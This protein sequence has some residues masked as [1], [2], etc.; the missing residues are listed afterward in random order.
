M[1]A[2]TSSELEALPGRYRGLLLNC[3]TAPKPAFLVGTRG[4]SS[5]GE[6]AVD[7]LSLF[8]QVIHLGANPFLIGLVI[9]PDVVERHT[10]RNLRQ[11]GLLTLSIV[12]QSMLPAAHQCSAK[13]PSEVSEFDAVGFERIYLQDFPVPAVAGS[14]V[15]MAL[16]VVEWNHIS[17]NDTSM[18]IAQVEHLYFSGSPGEDGHWN[19]AEHDVV[20]C[21][22][23][24]GYY[25]LN[26]LGR[27][28]Y[29]VV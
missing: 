25:G 16:N 14:P 29:A 18:A 21:G 7:N 5:D 3:F 17:T 4:R 1:P 10:L 23:L 27:Q 22:G 20:A 11:N 15:Q 28:G 9:R 2:Y 26:W 6:D 13:Y 8:S 19:G 24:D 12:T